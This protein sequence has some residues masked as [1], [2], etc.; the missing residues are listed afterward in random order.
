MYCMKKGSTCTISTRNIV[1]LVLSGGITG[2]LSIFWNDGIGSSSS[3]NLV[4]WFFAL[5]LLSLEVSCG[6]LGWN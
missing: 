3:V 1:E 4:D 5:A 2:L 6:L